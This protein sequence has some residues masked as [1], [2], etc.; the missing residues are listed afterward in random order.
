MQ[1]APP[2]LKLHTW[3]LCGLEDGVEIG[4]LEVALRAKFYNGGDS[5]TVG[6]EA[7]WL[8][9]FRLAWPLIPPGSA[10]TAGT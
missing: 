3:Y 10:N 4:K 2:A 7:S 5:V 1:P 6:L 9:V 8:Q